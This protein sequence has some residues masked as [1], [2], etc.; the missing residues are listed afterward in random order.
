V[1]ALSRAVLL[2]GAAA[3]LP[4]CASIGAGSVKRERLD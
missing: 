2:A 1:T 4:A 3:L